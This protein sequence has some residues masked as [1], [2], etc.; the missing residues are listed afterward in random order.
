MLGN[1]LLPRAPM[2]LYGTGGA[3]GAGADDTYWTE[4]RGPL[5]PPSLSSQPSL[6]APADADAASRWRQQN[7]LASS[8][9]NE[10][11][12]VSSG[13][14]LLFQGVA[15]VGSAAPAEFI[16]TVVEEV[17]AED[18]AKEVVLHASPLKPTSA[19]GSRTE[20]RLVLDR[21]LLVTEPG[22]AIDLARVKEVL[23]RC[24]LACIVEGWC[25]RE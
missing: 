16:V 24:S 23:H 25:L 13:S 9:E 17:R 8:G 19:D 4:G 3:M 7:S 1:K 22:G 5:S 6:E 11:T 20:H 15:N 21:Q 18:D 12:A 10:E 2:A 14:V